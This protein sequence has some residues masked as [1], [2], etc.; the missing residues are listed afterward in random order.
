MDVAPKNAV[1]IAGGCL[2]RSQSLLLGLP[3]SPVRRLNS[4][5][6]HLERVKQLKKTAFL[7]PF[8]PTSQGFVFLSIDPF[9]L[10][11]VKVK[12]KV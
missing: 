1:Y 6:H 5:Q 9:L 12:G 2:Y 10:I 8:H 4:G 7:Y 3:W 11:E